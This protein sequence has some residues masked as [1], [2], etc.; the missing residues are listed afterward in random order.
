MEQMQLQSL[1]EQLEEQKEEDCLSVSLNDV[2]L[3]R[4]D[5]NLFEFLGN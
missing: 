4:S 2:R 5:Q 3:I 1:Q